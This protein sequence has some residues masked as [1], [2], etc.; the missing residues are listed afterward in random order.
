MRLEKEFT[1]SAPLERAWSEMLDVDDLVSCLPAARM[2][3]LEGEEV[4]GGEMTIDVDGTSLECRGTV[5]PLDVDEDEHVATIQLDGRELA[6]PALGAGTIE[7]RVAG[8]NGSTS[9]TLRGDLKLTGQRADGEAV[10]QAA[11]RILDEFARRVEQRILE[12]KDE[13]PPVRE[14]APAPAVERRAPAA[15]S[16]EARPSGPVE[17]AL[18][19]AAVPSVAA[20][21]AMLLLVVLG[22]SRKRAYV[23]VKYRW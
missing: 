1:V 16:A 9:V 4:Y 11:A 23:V 5:R 6:G 14:P 3:R 22:R 19:G 2:S 7:T 20:L 18:R 13:A 15:A 17:E 8:G 10:E 12:R 21:L